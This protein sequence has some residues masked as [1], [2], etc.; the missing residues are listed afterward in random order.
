MQPNSIAEHEIASR[1]DAIYRKKYREQF[2]REYPGQFAV[3]DLHTEGAFVDQFP[4][5]ALDKAR[6]A[7]P[8]GVFFLVRIGARGAFKISR[9]FNAGARFI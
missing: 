9:M 5:K 2:E 4:E 6:K 1:G 7:Q 3:I 8:T